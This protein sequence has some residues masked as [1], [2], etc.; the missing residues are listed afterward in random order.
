MARQRA[1]LI[2]ARI[3]AGE[4]PVAEPLAAKP[5]GGGPTVGELAE[6]WLEEHVGTRCQPSAV[7]TYRKPPPWTAF[8]V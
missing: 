6:R 1:A 7:E 4:D 2:F 3:E 8:P 5:A